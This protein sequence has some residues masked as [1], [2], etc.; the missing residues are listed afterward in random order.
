MSAP[1]QQVPIRLSQETVARIVKHLGAVQAATGQRL[2]VHHVLDPD[3]ARHLDAVL[4]ELEDHMHD[5][6]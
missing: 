1:Y 5:R 3:S 6:T 2:P 4:D